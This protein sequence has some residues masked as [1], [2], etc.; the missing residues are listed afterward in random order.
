MSNED[1]LDPKPGSPEAVAQG[2]TCP[3]WIGSDFVCD[4]NC[5]LHAAEDQ[6]EQRSGGHIDADSLKS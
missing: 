5:P 3:P 6:V 4:P 2:C 1:F